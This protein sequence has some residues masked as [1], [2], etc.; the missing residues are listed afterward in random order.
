MA[1]KKS[2][3]PVASASITDFFPRR[4]SSNPS[5]SQTLVSQAPKQKLPPRHDQEVISVSSASHI[6]VSSG[7]RSVITVSDTSSRP[8][9]PASYDPMESISSRGGATRAALYHVKPLKSLP[10]KQSA[11]HSTSSKSSFKRKARLDSDSEI[12]SIDAGAFIH[13]SPARPRTSASSKPAPFAAKENLT[14]QLPQVSPIRKKPRI[15]SPE[16]RLPPIAPSDPGELVPS[17]QS[18][19]QNEIVVRG[20]ARDP[21]VVMQEVDRWRN[22]ARS[23]A[24]L[25]MSESEEN[26]DVE[27]SL[28]ESTSNDVVIIEELPA[29]AFTPEPSPEPQEKPLLSTPQP[30]LLPSFPATPVALT[31]ASKTAKIIADIKAKAYA[32]ALSS[33]EDSPLGELKE[34]EDSSDEEELLTGC[35]L[36]A[37]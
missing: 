7:A 11:K 17:S 16:P 14:H 10:A 30:R 36:F 18:D 23:P 4:A 37:V 19:E 6:T 34:L 26:M 2:K 20:S 8:R 33:P 5:S 15:S 24:S 22:E 27:M 28:P 9:A 21:E 29:V 35:A 3:G 12:E 1:P 31:E 25:P 13:S 32:N